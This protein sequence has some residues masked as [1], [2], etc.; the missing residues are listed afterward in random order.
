M[1]SKADTI[2]YNGPRDPQKMVDF[3]NE[4]CG[5]HRR[6]DGTL[7]PEAGIIPDF[8]KLGKDIILSKSMNKGDQYRPLIDQLRANNPGL[9]LDIYIHANIH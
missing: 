1:V 2:D 7:T 5:T 3:I 8:E 9:Y 6:L 4:Q